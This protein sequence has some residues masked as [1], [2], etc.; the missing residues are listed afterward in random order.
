[1]LRLVLFLVGVMAA[2]AVR[3]EGFMIIANPQVPVD[4]ISLEELTLIYLIEERIWPNDLPIVPVNREASS[5]L[6]AY[7]SEQVFNRTPADMSQYWNRMLYRGKVPPLVQT[8][9]A[10]ILGFV[11]SVPGAIGYVATGSKTTGVKVLME[12]Q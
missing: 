11:R 10:A 9:D 7:F 8:S 5:S 1:M 12:L 3:A 6:R 4:S 2:F